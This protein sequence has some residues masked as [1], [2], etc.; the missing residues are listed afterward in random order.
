MPAFSPI[1][2]LPLGPRCMIQA[3]GYPRQV[4]FPEGIPWG[5]P[6]LERSTAWRLA[7]LKA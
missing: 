5:E 2:G 6:A 4:K 7:P 1:R 3:T